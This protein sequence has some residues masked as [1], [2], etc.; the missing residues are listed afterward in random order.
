MIKRF[1]LQQGIQVQFGIQNLGREALTRKSW[2][3]NLS[4]IQSFL[5]AFNLS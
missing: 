3:H 1:A 4:T 2:R 5:N